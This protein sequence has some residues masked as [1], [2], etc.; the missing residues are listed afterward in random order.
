MTSSI[1]V[2]R[3]GLALEL[4]GAILLSLDVF[5]ISV[6]EPL[7]KVS[8]SIARIT[9]YAILASFYFLI[10]LSVIFDEFLENILGPILLLTSDDVI[11][12]LGSLPYLEIWI[13]TLRTPVFGGT[14][15]IG[16]LQIVGFIFLIFFVFLIVIQEGSSYNALRMQRR[17][18]MIGVANQSISLS[19][20]VLDSVIIILES[21]IGKDSFNTIVYISKFSTYIIIFGLNLVGIIAWPFIVAWIMP[22]ILI[23]IYISL[24]IFPLYCGIWLEDNQRVK[25]GLRFA[26]FII[27]ATGF[28][29]QI[30]WSFL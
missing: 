13:S 22:I 23:I 27:L 12:F 26:G 20:S 6:R 15:L 9:P 29:I 5:S 19:D 10:F 3:I 8:R 18:Q 1:W 24:P 17:D 30:I 16:I 25:S 14:P 4:V 11:R 28:F 21:K 7:Q 2:L